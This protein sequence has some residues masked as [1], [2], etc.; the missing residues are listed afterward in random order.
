MKYKKTEI[1][2]SNKASTKAKSPVLLT[3]ARAEFK[4]NFNF[5]NF[6]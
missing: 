1:V 3:K 4:E 6:N 2:K 5:D